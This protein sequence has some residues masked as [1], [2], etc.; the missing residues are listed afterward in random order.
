M[1][2][3]RTVDAVRQ[4]PRL[5]YGAMLGVDPDGALRLTGGIPGNVP[6]AVV[7]VLGG[8]HVAQATICLAV[9]S[10]VVAKVGGFVDGLH[11]VTDLACALL[12]RRQR[13]PALVD[14]AIAATFGL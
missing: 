11:A 1:S 13:R 6:R 4:A 3:G 14:A 8:R 9:R 12:D 2:R 10:P 5:V 7:R